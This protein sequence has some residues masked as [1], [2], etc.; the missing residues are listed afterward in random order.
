MVP[1]AHVLEHHS[2]GLSLVVFAPQLQTP[3]FHHPETHRIDITVG[4]RHQQ[5]RPAAA[6]SAMPG[7]LIQ[8]GRGAAG[9]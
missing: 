6:S 3:R 9:P 5:E 2:L 4:R 8:R 7:K 1:S